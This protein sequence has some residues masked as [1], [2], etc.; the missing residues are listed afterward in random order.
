[1]TGS[2]KPRPI[3][4]DPASLSTA[5][6]PLPRRPE[7]AVKVPELLERLP[8]L[9]NQMERLVERL[10]RLSVAS[11]QLVPAQPPTASLTNREAEILKG[12]MLGETGKATAR[13][14]GTSPSTVRAQVLSIYR[15]IGVKN[16]VQAA[17]WA[18]DNLVG[19]EAGHA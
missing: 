7:E 15:K 9:L 4:S 14:L 3:Q 10:E 18:R 16:R 1:M 2:C 11:P 5:G 19:S 13:R 6:L 17:V 12:I 8:E